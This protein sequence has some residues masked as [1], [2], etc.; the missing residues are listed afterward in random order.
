MKPSTF[1]KIEEY[2]KNK[3]GVGE[4]RAKKVAG[5]AYW[6]AAKSKYARLK[7]KA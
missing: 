4:E 7:S 2:A 1:E 6:G 5:A 3:Y